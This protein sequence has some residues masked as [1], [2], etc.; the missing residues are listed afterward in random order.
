MYIRKLHIC[1]KTVLYIIQIQFHNLLSYSDRFQAFFD[2]M[3]GSTLIL[4]ILQ[5]QGCLF[6]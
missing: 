2:L 4:S 6:W 1:H 5:V 3:L